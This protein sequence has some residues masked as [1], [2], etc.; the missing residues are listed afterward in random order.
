[1]ELKLYGDYPTVSSENAL[2]T[3]YNKTGAGS[4]YTGWL[5]LPKCPPDLDNIINTSNKLKEKADTLL[6][7][8][9]GG[10]YLGARA[11]IEYL[12][13][14]NYNETNEYKVYFSGT[15]LSGSELAHIIKIVE[16]KDIAVNII[17]KS[18]TTLEPALTFRV[19][20]DLM[21]KK[22]PGDYADRIVATTDKAKGTLKTLADSEGFKTFVIPDD[23]GGRYSVLTPVGLLPLAFAGADIKAIIDGANSA[24][25]ELSIKYAEVR[26]GLLQ[27]GKT[28][29]LLVSFE[30]NLRSLTEWWKQL[31]GESEGKD[32]KGI[33]PANLIYTTDLHSMG[34][35]V[36]DGM[37]NM[38]ETVIS[39]HSKN[40]DVVIPT[41]EVDDGLEYLA[42]KDFHYV[43]ERAKEGTIKA[44]LEGNVPV[45]EIILNAMNEQTLGELYYFFEKACG[46]SGYMLGVNPF[47]QPGVESYKKN[48]YS[49]LK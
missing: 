21:K 28:T 34:Q 8:G 22:Y 27:D 25:E 1:M 38:F 2:N 3:L 7:I 13:G 44:H 41:S 43:N 48:M 31:F 40:V 12:Y 32:G 5:D 17:S 35:Y 47:T 29:E 30:P 11:G 4:E 14:T 9:I 18:G 33:F 45:M 20:L 15:S 37:R 36:Q 16:N 23:V 49:L 39:F 46:I 19:I 10:S 42:G 24:R 6:V 26:N